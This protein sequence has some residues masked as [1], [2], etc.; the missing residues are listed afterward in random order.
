M[1]STGNRNQLAALFKK[2]DPA[3]QRVVKKVLV[4]EQRQIDSSRPRV[5]D[6]IRQ[7]IEEEVEQ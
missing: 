2:Y 3:V 1:A 6:D 4:L 7:A 5:K